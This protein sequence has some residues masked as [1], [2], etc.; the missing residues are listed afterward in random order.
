ME[1]PIRLDRCYFDRHRGAGNSDQLGNHQGAALGRVEEVHPQSVQGVLEGRQ[2]ALR[3]STALA[4]RDGDFLFLVFGRV[5]PNGLTSIWER[6]PAARRNAHRAA[7]DFCRYRH[8][9]RQPCGGTFVGRQDRT[10]AG[11]S[12]RRGHGNILSGTLCRT[13]FVQFG[14]MGTGLLGILRRFLRRP[15]ECIVTTTQWPRRERPVDRDEQCFQ[16]LGGPCGLGTALGTFIAALFFSGSHHLDS[17]IA[18]VRLDR[19]CSLSSA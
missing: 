9:R 1:R 8:R 2:D 7:M 19:L 13:A 10:G 17:G 5:P 11:S 3:R 16:H 4:H 6:N 14:G 18:H 12:R 15:S